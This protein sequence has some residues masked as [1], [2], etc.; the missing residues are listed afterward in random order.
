MSYWGRFILWT[1]AVMSFLAVSGCVPSDSGPSDDE[2]ELHYVRGKNC[3]NAM[4]YAGA[5]ESFRES[6]AVNPHSAPAHF[7]LAM[8]FENQAADPAAAIY[9]YQEFLRLN[10]K[11]DNADVVRQRI[12]S[13]KVQLASNVGS[14]PSSPTA[15]RQLEELTEKNRRLQEEVEKWRAYFNA[16]KNQPAPGTTPVQTGPVRSAG[17]GANPDT[18]AGQ[19]RTDSSGTAPG[20]PRTPPSSPPART[21]IVAQGDT[22]AAIA[23][24]NGVST[25]A[26]QAANPGVSP[27]KL[28]PGQTLNLPG[29]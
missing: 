12:E 20:S 22:L 13:C 3:V 6:L 26:L 25:A 18:G 11:A 14:L 1:V 2:K 9:H 5:I 23:R 15:L 28:K 21:C 8:L 4:D 10:P 29:R 16:Q 17:G 19:A 24:K 7:Q 27:K